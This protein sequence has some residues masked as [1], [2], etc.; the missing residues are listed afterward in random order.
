M[1]RGV[2]G[3]GC[4]EQLGECSEHMAAEVNGVLNQGGCP[5]R[6][7]VETGTVEDDASPAT[8]EMQ[9]RASEGRQWVHAARD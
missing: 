1:T 7:W 6:S 9:I 3:N 2:Y 4:T 8:G 5:D